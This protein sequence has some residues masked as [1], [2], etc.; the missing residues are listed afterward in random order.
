MLRVYLV[1]Y[2]LTII[3]ADNKII[4]SMDATLDTSFYTLQLPNA[5]RSFFMKLVKNMGW[6][7]KLQKEQNIPSATLKAIEE[8]RS[9]KDAGTID[10]S[11][12][13]AFM[14]SME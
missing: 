12:L 9:G 10:T 6:I 11:S 13:E 4:I 1:F 2:I 8:A 14:K 7:A 5:D 3:F